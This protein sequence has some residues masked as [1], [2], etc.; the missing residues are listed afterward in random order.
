MKLCQLAFCR[1]FFFADGSFQTIY[2]R[3]LACSVFKVSDTW[4]AYDWN[5]KKCVCVAGT[6]L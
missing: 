6:F 4:K 5:V 2:D 1:V 3:D